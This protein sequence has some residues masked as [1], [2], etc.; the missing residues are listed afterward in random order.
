MVVLRALKPQTPHH[1]T[2]TS[3]MAVLVACLSD[4]VGTGRISLFHLS[5]SSQKIFRNLLFCEK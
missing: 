2:T 1:L 3:L 5:T 4:T